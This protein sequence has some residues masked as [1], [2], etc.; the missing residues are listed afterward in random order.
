MSARDESHDGINPSSDWNFSGNP[1]ENRKSDYCCG[2]PPFVEP[3]EGSPVGS[4]DS[5][6][7]DAPQCL[8]DSE[9]DQEKL[10][11]RGQLRDWMADLYRAFGPAHA[12]R[13]ARMCKC[14][15]LLTYDCYRIGDCEAIHRVMVNASYCRE[16]LCPLCMW[17][18]SLWLHAQLC[19]LMEAYLAVHPD[20]QA[21]L[22]TL[23][24][25]N[26]S[27]EKLRYWV[28]KLL[29]AFRKL[30]RYK[31]VATA[32]SAWW[33]V[34][35]ITR[36]AETGELHPHLHVILL[37]PPSYFKKA[38]GLYITQAKWVS[39]FR[40][41]LGVDYNPI[42]DIRPL[43][44]VGG[45]APL[46]EEGKKSLY[47]G[48]KYVCEPGMF[49]DGDLANFPLR[50]IHEAV[51]GRRLIGMSVSL[52]DLSDELSLDDEMPEDFEPATALPEGAVLIGRETYQWQRGHTHAESRYVLVSFREWNPEPKE[53]VMTSKLPE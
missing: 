3:V 45:G 15:K 23:T 10:R 38:A 41:A 9:L 34:L 40:K 8:R 21:L 39:L 13:A 46:D 16:R 17:R 50:E 2:R 30:F 52:R 47:E 37:V 1:Q 7:C 14:G 5:A 36:N 32:I 12:S 53:A 18:H 6:E 22:L 25:K 11:K 33:R 31:A 42:C 43:R 48:C 49:M 24:M 27:A 20:H 28:D 26:M 4:E 35:E 51:T 44:G 19:T 29:N